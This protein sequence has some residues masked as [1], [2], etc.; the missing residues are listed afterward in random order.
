MDIITSLTFEMPGEM[1]VSIAL[2]EDSVVDIGEVFRVNLLVPPN[3][4]II[5]TFNAADVIILDQV[6]QNLQ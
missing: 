3:D 1:C 2:E 4:D 6:G 5:T